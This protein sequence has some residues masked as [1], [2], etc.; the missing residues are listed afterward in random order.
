VATFT[1]QIA[2]RRQDCDAAKW[3]QIQQI[4]VT[5][6]EDVGAPVHGGLEELVVPGIA[7]GAH[8]ADDRHHLGNAPKQTDELLPV[9]D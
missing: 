5:G 2:S 8:D 4:L 6:H 7:T 3:I 9:G 1:T